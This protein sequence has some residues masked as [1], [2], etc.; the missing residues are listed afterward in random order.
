MNR[1]LC[2]VFEELEELATKVN[3]NDCYDKDDE[4]SYNLVPTNFLAPSSTF[5]ILVNLDVLSSQSTKAKNKCGHIVQT[6][7]YSNMQISVYCQNCN[8]SDVKSKL[9]SNEDDGELTIIEVNETNNEEGMV[10]THGKKDI[11]NDR[12]RSDDAAKYRKNCDNERVTLEESD[13]EET[14]SKEVINDSQI[15]ISSVSISEEESCNE[16][17]N[18]V[19]KES[20]PI[21]LFDTRIEAKTKQEIMDI[22]EEN[23]SVDIDVSLLS[24]VVELKEELVDSEDRKTPSQV[25]SFRVKP[26]SQLLQTTVDDNE[27]Y[28]HNQVVEDKYQTDSI[29]VIDLGDDDE[30]PTTVGSNATGGE[31]V[32]QEAVAPLMSSF[33]IKEFQ[34]PQHQMIAP[35]MLPPPSSAGVRPIKV[36]PPGSR[37]QQQPLYKDGS[38]RVAAS[39]WNPPNTSPD[40]ASQHSDQGARISG[41]ADSPGTIQRLSAQNKVAIKNLMQKSRQYQVSGQVPAHNFPTP[42]RNAHNFSTPVRNQIFLQSRS[43]YY[44]TNP[45]QSFPSGPD[46]GSVNQVQS[47]MTSPGSSYRNSSS[48][49]HNFSSPA[50]TH[51]VPSPVNHGFQSRV[52]SPGGIPGQVNHAMIMQNNSLRYPSPNNMNE[53]RSRKPGASPSQ[54]TLPVSS[55][56]MNQRYHRPS[57]GQP[58]QAMGAPSPV[59]DVAPRS[60]SPHARNSSLNE[61]PTRTGAASNLMVMVQVTGVGPQSTPLYLYDPREPL[62]PGYQAVPIERGWRPTVLQNTEK[63]TPVILTDP[64][65]RQISTGEELLFIK[66]GMKRL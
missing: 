49:A 12:S 11:I 63:G 46:V 3:Q 20:G 37:Q 62:P 25:P 44:R 65:G 10:D 59:Y 35:L 9:S 24:P 16:A 5:S 26:L 29:P 21:L 15:T 57:L 41:M 64:Q 33:P 34:H 56:H 28:S 53:P 43:P 36:D 4:E 66:Y 54:G 60:S 7:T 52:L 45:R 48:P 61:P 55:Y 14:E 22:K 40:L 42:V 32:A 1:A 31:R 13:I 58:S 38:N 50:L 17:V 27:S 47:V 2:T 30:P 19:N 51:S 8:V 18:S 39:T 6:V 23:G